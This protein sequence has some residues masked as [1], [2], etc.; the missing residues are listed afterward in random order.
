MTMLQPVADVGHL[1]RRRD[2]MFP[3]AHVGAT[4]TWSLCSCLLAIETRNSHPNVVHAI[5]PLDGEWTTTTRQTTALVFANEMPAMV[6]SVN[7]PLMLIER[8]YC[9]DLVVSTKALQSAVTS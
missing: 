7:D 9:L 4:V 3:T 8:E 5:D 2:P 1:R 6:D